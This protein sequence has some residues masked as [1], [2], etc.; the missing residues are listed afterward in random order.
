[1]IKQQHLD[2]VVLALCGKAS[3]RLAAGEILAT[4]RRA[5]KP[6]TRLARNFVDAYRHQIFVLGAF[7]GDPHPGNL[8]IT[9]EGRICFHDFGSI[10][11]LDSAARRKLA[12]FTNT[13]IR[14]DADWLL[15]AATDLGVLGGQMDRAYF[16][17]GLSEI[18]ADYAALAMRDWSLADA[19][20]RLFPSGCK[21]RGLPIN[22]CA[23]V[24]H[25][26]ACRELGCR[27]WPRAGLRRR[28]RH[29]LRGR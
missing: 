17:R 25:R 16:R 14:Q 13:F 18:I 19:F 23:G 24:D 27:Q 21:N 3:D 2:D 28:A 1:M 29:L 10:G 15:D 26:R 7:H 12:A 11:V 4:T 9:P 22:R 6:R 5:N 20:L 8:F